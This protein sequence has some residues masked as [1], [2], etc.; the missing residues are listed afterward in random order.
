MGATK[1]IERKFLVRRPPPG[2]RRRASVRITQGYLVSGTKDPE[3]RLRR[4]GA[5]HFLTIKGGHGLRR[6]EQEI[7]IP[8]STFRALW[9]MTASQRVAKRR[10]RIPCDGHTVE[11]DVYRG[12]H[13]GLKTAEVEFDS[14]RASRS[15]HPP[16]W[17][18]R[19]ITGNRRYAN[20]V[21]ARQGALNR[22]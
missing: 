20:S 15:F 19:E 4:E 11:M 10:Y 2:W 3:I 7:P 14:V 16:G 17:L 12:Y 18:G 1:E 8:A 22:R 6:S 13:R 5:R 9:P 21:L